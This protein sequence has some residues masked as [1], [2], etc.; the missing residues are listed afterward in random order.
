MA[1]S[2]KSGVC[3]LV[4]AGPGDPG[5][6]TLRGRDCLLKADV[7]VYDYLS[8]PEFLRIAPDAAESI[9]V[10]KKAGAHTMKQDDINALLV[11][12]T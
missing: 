9:Y 1:K 3:Y 5:L 10:G 11:R 12:L 2:N 6:L 7:V 4:G 8:N